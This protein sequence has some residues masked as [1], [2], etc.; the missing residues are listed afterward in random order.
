MKCVPFK[1]LDDITA[2]SITG[3]VYCQPTSKNFGALDSFILDMS[4]KEC[5]G[6]QMTINVAHGINQPSLERF[7]KGLQTTLDIKF[8]NFYFGFM[9]PK[10]LAKAFP[11]QKI[12]TA[13]KSVHN[14][15]CDLHDM[16]QYV[17]PCDP[18]IGMRTA[19]GKDQ[20]AF[21]A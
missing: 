4:S 14:Q 2:E 19:F 9:V 3:I 20:D 1:K 7:I 15:P 5:F 12:L 17:V 16:K 21:I 6:L 10:K 11:E 13:T 8:S 18:S